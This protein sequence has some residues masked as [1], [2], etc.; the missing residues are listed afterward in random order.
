VVA[1][2]NEPSSYSSSTTVNYE[3]GIKSSLLDH[4]FTAELSAFHIDWQ[5]IQLQAV[6]GGFNQFVNGGTARSDGAEWNFA[7]LPVTGLTLNFNG[8]YTHAYLTEAT[9]ASVNGQV[10]DRLPA[11]PLFESAVSAEYKRSLFGDYSGFAAADSRFTGSRYA[12][13][14]ATGPRQTMPSFNI[15]DLRAGVETQRWTFALYVKNVAN[16]IA[17][18]YVQPEALS[19]GFGPQSAVIYTLRT[20]GA[21]VTANF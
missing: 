18:N 3:A 10:G 4:H 1:T 14:S 13:F 15:V 11:V 21:T 9:P 7:Y 12:N 16:K 17:I 8:A 2:A 19:G 5:K 6:I 20:V